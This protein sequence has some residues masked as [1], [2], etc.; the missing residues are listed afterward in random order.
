MSVSCRK[1]IHRDMNRHFFTAVEAGETGTKYV[2]AKLIIIYDEAWKI[3]VYVT[4]HVHI[5]ECACV[6][7]RPEMSAEC[8]PQ[9]LYTLV[10]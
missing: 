6:V 8:F 9:L 1:D 4:R 3:C 7:W 10:F 2:N 5:H